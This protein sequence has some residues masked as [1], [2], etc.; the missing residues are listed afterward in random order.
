MTAAL[1]S[2]RL[3][4]RSSL[5]STRFLSCTRPR[6]C[7]I[8]PKVSIQ[9]KPIASRLWMSTKAATE[10]IEKKAAV[11]ATVAAAAKEKK[12][13]SQAVRRLLQLARPEAKNISGKRIDLLVKL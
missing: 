9:P 12:A 13:D 3:L 8:I 5:T 6:P 11:D 7:M 2:Q 4:L 10:A 1:L